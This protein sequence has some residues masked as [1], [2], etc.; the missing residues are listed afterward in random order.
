MELSNRFKQIHYFGW[1]PLSE[2]E[3][4]LKNIDYCLMPSRFLETFGLSAINVLKRGI[5]VVG[6]KK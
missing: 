4:Y 3:R 2:V 6:F 1:K 5:P